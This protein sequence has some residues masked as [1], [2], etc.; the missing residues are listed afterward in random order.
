MV[1]IDKKLPLEDR[2]A[3][4]RFFSDLSSNDRRSVDLVVEAVDNLA[5]EYF[6]VTNPKIRTKQDLSRTKKRIDEVAQNHFQ[7][8]RFVDGEYKIGSAFFAVYVIGGQI[9]KDLPRS[10]IDL[11]ISTNMWRSGGYFEDSEEWL[12]DSLFEKM[13]EDFYISWKGDLPNSYDMGYHKSKSV[14][15]LNPKHEGFSPIDILYV[16]SMQGGRDK[17]RFISREEFENKDIEPNG[18]GLPKVLIYQSTRELEIP[19]A[20]DY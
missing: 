3:R 4:K 1:F 16:R 8:K 5:D 11:M 19:K 13:S 7:F 14:L 15:D 18:K 6:G 20:R 12:F 9:T 17:D 2:D 10:D